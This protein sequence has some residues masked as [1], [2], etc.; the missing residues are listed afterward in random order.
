MTG[1]L[2]TG[3]TSLHSITDGL[4][5][6]SLDFCPE[7][8]V[9]HEKDT[10]IFLMVNQISLIKVHLFTSLLSFFPSDDSLALGN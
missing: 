8:L 5:L 4:L 9:Y 1:K 2:Y 3:D 7:N 10:S 6:V